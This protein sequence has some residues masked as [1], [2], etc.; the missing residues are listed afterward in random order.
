[1]A[2]SDR[3]NWQNSL[4]DTYEEFTTQIIA[5][6]PLLAGAVA[7]LIVGWFVAHILRIATRKLIRGLKLD[8]AGRRAGRGCQGAE[9]KA[10]LRRHCR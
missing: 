2:S 9:D 4:V 3:I 8:P 7:V 10:F 6:A 1:M 5:F